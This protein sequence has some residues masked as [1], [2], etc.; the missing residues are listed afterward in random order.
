MQASSLLVVQQHHPSSQGNFGFP[1]IAA[2]WR[3]S[4]MTTHLLVFMKSMKWNPK[5]LIRVE[6]I[7]IV[8][9]GED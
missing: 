4:L 3:G 6:L 8:S 1:F 7:T 9:G 2:I 5:P